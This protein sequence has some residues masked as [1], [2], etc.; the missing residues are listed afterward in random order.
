MLI[1]HFAWWVFFFLV[2]FWYPDQYKLAFSWWELRFEFPSACND[3]LL[4]KIFLDKSGVLRFSKKDGFAS[5]SFME[6]GWS[7]RSIY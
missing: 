2:N 5:S 1:L 7:Y 4:P 6:F 3:Q